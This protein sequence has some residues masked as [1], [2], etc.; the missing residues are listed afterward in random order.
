MTDAAWIEGMRQLAFLPDPITDPEIKAERSALY[1]Q[2]LD[3]LSDARWLYAARAA[4]RSERWF[5]TVAALFDYATAYRPDVAGLLPPPR[6]AEQLEADRESCR[7]GL[8]LIRQAVRERAQ[9][10][11]AP[12]TPA[13]Y[14]EP[15]AIVVVR[16][17]R[18]AELKAGLQQ[19]EG[20]AR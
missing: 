17:E 1:R 10:E 2:E 11:P 4:F 18:I 14:R 5:P 6:S 16:E 15:A 7:R 19:A 3:E 8:E 13:P 12:P 9:K 20:E